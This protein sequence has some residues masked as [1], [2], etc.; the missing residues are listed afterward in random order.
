MKIGIDCKRIYNYYK[1]CPRI[2]LSTTHIFDC[3][4]V[5]KAKENI[6]LSPMDKLHIA[7]TIFSTHGS[8]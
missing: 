5:L 6:D 4:A 7:K 3:P 2:E 8:I 1:H